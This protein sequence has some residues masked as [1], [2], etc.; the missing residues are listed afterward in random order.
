MQVD[1]LIIG[2]GISGTMLSYEFSRAGLSF[3]VIDDGN[4]SS[5]SRVAAGM[6]NP[7][8]G[9]RIVKTW[10]IDELLPFAFHSY[11]EMGSVLNI[12]AIHETPV[13][14]FFSNQ[15]MQ[16]AFYERVEDI[17]EYLEAGQANEQYEDLF[18]F[19][20]GY[21]IIRPAYTVN[22]RS[23]LP[24]WKNRLQQNG[25]LIETRFDVSSMQL[26]DDGV[27][28]ESINAAKIIF[29][30]GGSGADLSWFKNL[31]FA[32]NKGQALIIEIENM[33]SRNIFAKGLKM[34]PLGSNLFWVGSSYEWDFTEQGPT[35]AFRERTMI[36]LND[37]L[38]VPF[39]LADHV[40][41]LRPATLERRPFVGFH[42]QFRQVGIFNGMGTKGYSLAPYF[43]RQFAEHIQFSTPIDPAADLQRFKK[44]L[45]R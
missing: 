16:S 19:N 31:P 1:Y 15:Q 20:Y 12:E 40:A 13:I 2:L 23:L 39:K 30:N 36:Q 44:V 25:Q 21:G 5:S 17:P 45:A 35:S 14:D 41:A 34:L 7:V 42:P 32:E 18:R 22:T 43:A 38:K 3:V 9:R 6:I 11:N 28:F 33:P 29:C 27:R 10:M 37:W 8:T 4:P 26:T 24:A